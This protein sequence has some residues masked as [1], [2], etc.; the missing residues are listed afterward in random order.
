MFQDPIYLRPGWMSPIHYSAI[1]GVH[2]DLNPYNG[3]SKIHIP[4]QGQTTLDM[5]RI[6]GIPNYNTF[7]N[8]SQ[9]NFGTL[10]P[11]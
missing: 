9:N 6:G 11:R 5:Y 10:K 3:A 2:A 7:N 8:I 1:N 4:Y